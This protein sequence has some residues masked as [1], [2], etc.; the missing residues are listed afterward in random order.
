MKIIL[1]ILRSKCALSRYS[2]DAYAYSLLAMGC[3]DLKIKSSMQFYDIQA[4]IA[5]RN[6]TGG[7]FSDWNGGCNYE[8]GRILACGD[9]RIHQEALKILSNFK[10]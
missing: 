10:K 8:S 7:V 5:L 4:P 6:S 3:L 9:K 1:W 2:L